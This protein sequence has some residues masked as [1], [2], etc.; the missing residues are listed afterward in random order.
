MLDLPGDLIAVLETKMYSEGGWLD[1]LSFSDHDWKL[2]KKN[3]V[4]SVM[5]RV[6][7]NKELQMLMNGVVEHF[8]IHSKSTR[9][10]TQIYFPLFIF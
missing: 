4:F 8:I 3:L 10:S 7:E 2:I 9:L 5:Q 1:E 6:S